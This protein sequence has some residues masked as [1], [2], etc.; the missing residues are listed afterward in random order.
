MRIPKF[1][2]KLWRKFKK[3]RRLRFWLRRTAFWSFVIFSVLFI[4]AYIS[5]PSIDELNRFTRAP[6]VLLKS[7]D[8]K[9]IGSFG[10]IYGDYISYDDFPKSLIDA[11]VATE[12]RS[13]FSHF[14]IDVTGLL[15]ATFANL[16][17]GHVV[18]GGST[19][20][21]QVAKNVFL[22][23][24][25]S[26]SRKF[27]EMMLALA[28]ERKFS[29]K[30]IM[31][32]YLNR[33]YLGAGNY[34]V[35][36][37]A[38]RYFG[39]SARELR[40]SE[41]AILAGMLKAPSRYAPTNNPELATKRAELVLLNMEDAGF[42]TKAQ[43]QKA[44][45]ELASTIGNRQRDSQS[46]FYFADWIMDQIPEYVGNIQEDLIVTTT[47]DPD[48]QLLGDKAIASVMNEQ[49]EKLKVSQAAL[50]SMTPDG[51]VRAL[52]GGRSYATS[53]YNR[54]T[55][56]LRQPGSS[57]K[58]FVYL[59]GL[60]SGIGPDTIVDDEPMTIPIVGGTWTPKN[61]TNKYLG[62]I[63]LRDAVAE[64]VNTVA[65]R[66]SQEAGLS[67]VIGVARRLGITSDMLEVPSIALG[68]TEVSLLELTNAYA[69]LANGGMLVHP[70]GIIRIETTSGNIVYERQGSESAMV[71]K[72]Y[73]VGEMNELLRGVITN[74]TGRAANIGR[75]AAGKTGT[76][77][78]YKDAWFIGYTPDLVTGVWVGNDNNMPMKKVT[79][80]MLPAQIWHNFMQPA[81]ASVPASDIPTDIPAPMPWQKDLTN[82]TTAPSNAL[83]WQ[84]RE[85]VPD[86]P[87]PVEVNDIPPQPKNVKLG[88][89]FWDKLNGAHP[90]R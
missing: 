7:E 74:G 88:P 19:I 53:Q 32:I 1:I 77:S 9:I 4:W 81:L 57:F 70:Y 55:Q 42:L 46:S 67:H 37:A 79:G 78:D 69:H 51:A 45:T 90:N 84:M 31:S 29:K 44:A 64:S 47:F 87:A 72:P 71:L 33:V 43:A 56:A 6:S 85:D 16:R 25:R 50:L 60:E 73:V 66:V 80:G 52:I 61:Y 2:K 35:D 17:A 14:G 12:D 38:R 18:Q 34:G 62:P 21:Q 26:M 11:V 48:M 89:E 27:R 22:T 8:G 63:S 82:E 59:A 41:S 20:T 39:K 24:E 36:S 23:P 15:R 86:E 49:A 5:L 30:E 3:A 83:P 58:I 40:L 28:I 65:V 76:T 10:D 75:S 54:V 68:A 13:F